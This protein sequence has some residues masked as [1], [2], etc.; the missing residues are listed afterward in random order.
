MCA[1]G[2]PVEQGE[3]VDAVEEG[4]DRVF[5]FTAADMGFD[6]NPVSKDLI[7]NGFPWT[8]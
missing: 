2:I 7:V 5:I 3:S 4:E 1:Y 8:N 6:S